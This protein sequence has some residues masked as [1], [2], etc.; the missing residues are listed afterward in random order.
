MEAEAQANDPE[1]EALEEK[2][3]VVA[4]ITEEQKLLDILDQQV[5]HSGITP[6]LLNTA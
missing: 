2:A 6:Q 4:E 5:K 3:E 1:V